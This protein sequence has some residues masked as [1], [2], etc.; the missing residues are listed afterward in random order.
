ML[1]TDSQKTPL[2]A[3]PAN[4][5][6]KQRLRHFERYMQIYFSVHGLMGSLTEYPLYAYLNVS[7]DYQY[8]C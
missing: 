7:Y 3:A 6:N 8:Y 5:S 4:Y 2:S 1:A